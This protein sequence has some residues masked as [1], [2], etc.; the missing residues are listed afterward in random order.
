MT[1][2]ELLCAYNFHDCDVITPFMVQGDDITVTFVLAKHLQYDGI[3]SRQN[4][5][6]AD[7]EYSLVVRIRFSECTCIK[8]N[9]WTYETHKATTSKKS[10]KNVRQMTVEQFDWQLDFDSVCISAERGISF[11]FVGPKQRVGDISFQCRDI[12]IEEETLLDRT[13]YDALWGDSE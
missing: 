13:G 11:V 3:Q 6:Y 7:K 10:R 12:E 5:L 4:P 9:E 8:A 1:V 2:D